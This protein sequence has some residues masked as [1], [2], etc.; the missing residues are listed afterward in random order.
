[1][2][3]LESC[4]HRRSQE[5]LKTMPLVQEVRHPKSLDRKN[6]RK[7]VLLRE[8]GCTWDHIPELGPHRQCHNVA[9]VSAVHARPCCVLE[10][11]ALVCYHGAEQF[12]DMPPATHVAAHV[13]RGLWDEPLCL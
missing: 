13:C 5:D 9:A 4:L 8:T 3:S 2:L 7:A 6:E 1:M 12:R 10:C 11:V